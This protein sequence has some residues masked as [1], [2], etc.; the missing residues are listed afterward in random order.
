MTLENLRTAL[1]A[2]SV[3]A[4]AAFAGF[5]GSLYASEIKRAFP[6]C[7]SECNGPIVWEAVAFWSLFLSASLL[8][9]CRH[10]QVDRRRSE[11]VHRLYER[12]R[13]FEILLRT[14]PPR[15]FLSNYSANY[16]T[17]FSAVAEIL[18]GDEAVRHEITIRTAVHNVF[19]AIAALARSFDDRPLS[20][21]SVNLMTFEAIETIRPGWSVPVKFLDTSLDEKRSELQGL[22]VLRNAYSVALRSAA[23]CEEIPDSRLAPI[24]LP[25]PRTWMNGSGRFRALPGAPLAFCERKANYFDDTSAMAD[26]CRALGD[27]PESVTEE[28]QR[29]FEGHRYIGSL[30]SFPVLEPVDGADAQC[31][32][33]VNIHSDEK[34]I[35]KR[36]EGSEQFLLLMRPFCALLYELMSLDNFPRGCELE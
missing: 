23:Q 22:L 8:F 24:A 1:F 4:I 10:V 17:A 20:Y 6:F 26:F 33:V 7:G 28:T 27:F 34:G 14:Q 15:S 13:D 16:Q 30:A 25:V 11:E 31:V 21:Y 3:S 18:R 29:Y 19:L 36:E 35:L 12:A 5:A 32:G 9:M 2:T